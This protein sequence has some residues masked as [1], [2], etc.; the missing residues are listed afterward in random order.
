[1]KSQISFIPL[2]LVC[3]NIFPWQRERI[4]LSRKISVL[5]THFSVKFSMLSTTYVTCLT[6]VA[7]HVS[8]PKEL[9][10]K[11]IERI[12]IVLGEDEDAKR[13]ATRV[14][15]KS[16]REKLALMLRDFHMR[17]RRSTSRSPGREVNSSGMNGKLALW[18]HYRC[19]DA[20]LHAA[21]SFLRTGSVLSN[22]D[23]C[24]L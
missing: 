9:E 12:E 11:E 8:I 17:D 15:V 16:W 5:C 24:R 3:L 23:L 14:K 10:K 7:C 19:C 1:M 2:H 20:A 13:V 6:E 22:S 18:L 4:I 21:R